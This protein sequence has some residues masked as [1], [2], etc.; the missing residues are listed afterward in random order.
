MGPFY[1]YGLPAWEVWEVIT[2]RRITFNRRVRYSPLSLIEGGGKPSQ[3]SIRMGG[4]ES[5]DNGETKE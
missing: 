3:E 5:S 4:L 1:G 2:R